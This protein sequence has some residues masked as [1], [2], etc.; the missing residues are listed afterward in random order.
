MTTRT[1]LCITLHDSAAARAVCA[2]LG[3][4][5]VQ[6]ADTVDAA[7]RLLRVHGPDTG[8]PGGVGLLFGVTA[9]DAAA[10]AQ[11]LSRHPGMEWI[12]V[13]DAPALASPDCRELISAY[14]YDFHT[15]PVDLAR[16][17]FSLGHALGCA[18]LRQPP[19]GQAIDGAAA[20]GL[21]GASLAL[22][23]LR[24]QI[25]K[26]ARADAP[27]LISGESGSGKELTAVAIH[28]G[29]ERARGPFVT[30]NCG[31]IPAGL[32]QSE[33]FGHV[34]G[35]FTGAA[36]DKAGLIEAASGGTVFLDEIADLPKDMQS[37]LL[38]FLQ[39]K[40]IYRLGATRSISVDV[41]VVAASHVELATAVAH[42]AFRE[43]L[44]YRLAVLPLRVPPLRERRDDV[45]LL[46]AH[47]FHHYASDRPARLKGFSRAA[48]EALRAHDWPGNVRELINRTRRALVLAEGRLIVPGDLGLAAPAGTA[49]PMPTQAP[50]LGESR[51]LAERL[52]IR[53]SLD[54][55]GGNVAQAARELGVSRMTLYRLLD[56]HAISHRD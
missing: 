11:L 52:A 47:F 12:G 5:R 35:A 33:L 2:S 56:R 42:G 10:L 45:P 51:V 23:R 32:I 14:L 30:I 37:N 49:H 21:V 22:V 28:A 6:L 27:V 24:Q 16:L 31:A 46:A 38:R 50:G 54:R 36:R 9:R 53:C 29:S 15:F 18:A 43:D 4:W 26:M 13:F 19:P 55:A 20:D 1:L 40:T 34:R 25:R 48:L 7:A 41:R 44:Y 3:G 39:E 8:G 17:D